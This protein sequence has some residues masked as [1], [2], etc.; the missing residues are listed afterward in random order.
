MAMDDAAPAH[1]SYLHALAIGLAL[2]LG[3]EWGQPML[4][5]AQPAGTAAGA[6]APPELPPIQEAETIEVRAPYY[7]RW[8][9]WTIVAVVGAGIAV[10]VAGS[11]GGGSPPPSGSV[12]VTGPAP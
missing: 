8:W 9:F 11:G 10:A 7:K 2:V 5:L 3:C 12:T 4:L 6:V 1:F